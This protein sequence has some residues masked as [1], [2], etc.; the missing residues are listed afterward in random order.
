MN[1]AYH[2]VRHTTQHDGQIV[3]RHETNDDNDDG[4]PDVEIACWTIGPQSK[5]VAL[6]S[7]YDRSHIGC[8]GTYVYVYLDGKELS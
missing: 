6:K 4:W 5:A 8:G 3:S 2:I 1:H 7:P